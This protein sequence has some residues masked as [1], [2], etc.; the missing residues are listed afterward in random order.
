MLSAFR[1]YRANIKTINRLKKRYGCRISYKS[2]FII[3]SE[4]QIALNKG[5]YIGA[6]TVIASQSYQRPEKTKLTVGSNTY[7]GE[8]NNIRISDAGIAIGNNC[9]I[10]QMVSLIS[11]NHLIEGAEKLTLTNGLDYS[12]C[13]I[14]IGTDVWIGCNVVVLPGVKIGNGAVIG[15]GSVVTADIPEYSIAVGSPAKVI[16]TR[17]QK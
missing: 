17:N 6:G 8:N 13:G 12:K 4:N 3:E 9:M 11:T 7:I 16:K 14:E 5:V 15:A 10:S 1:E 2:N